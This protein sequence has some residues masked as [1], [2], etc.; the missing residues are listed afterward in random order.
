MFR[1]GFD[2]TMKKALAL[3][4]AL[5]LTL[6]CFAGCSGKKDDSAGNVNTDKLVILEEPLTTE[7]YGFATKLGNDSLI[8]AINKELT[9]MLAD[10][11]IKSIFEKYDAPY[12]SDAA[13]EATEASDDSL[14]KVLDA[15]KLVIA[16]SPDFPPFEN[17]EDDGSIVGIEIDVLNLICEKLGVKLEIQQMDFDAILPGLAAGKYDLGVSGFTATDERKQSALFT[18]PYCLAAISIVVPEGSAIKGKADL[19]GKA[20]SCQSG[21]TAENYCMANGINYKSFA[22]N[23]DAEMALT[24]GKVEAWAIDDLTAAE[25]V[26]AYNNK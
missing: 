24:T 21:T 1:K 12:T 20:V 3:T 13:A 5:V 26:A 4:M 17:L 16:T 25:L 22:A 19:A 9:A 2:L 8:Q 6:L 14:Q 11:T 7:P 10:G 18:E 23:N 15:G